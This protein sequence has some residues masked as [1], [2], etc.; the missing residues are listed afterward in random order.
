MY[1]LAFWWT[2][3]QTNT[4]THTPTH[5]HKQHINKI[6]PEMKLSIGALAYFTEKY[7]GREGMGNYTGTQSFITPINYLS[8]LKKFLKC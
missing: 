1:L 8:A 7:T 2:N 5:T 6:Y 3:T 4:Y